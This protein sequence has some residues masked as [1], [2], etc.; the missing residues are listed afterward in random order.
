MS[1]FKV[2]Q[3]FLYCSYLPAVTIKSSSACSYI[4]CQA[5]RHFWVPHPIPEEFRSSFFLLINS[6]PLQ[7]SCRLLIGHF[8]SYHILND[9]QNFRPIN[10]FQ[11]GNVLLKSKQIGAISFPLYQK[12]IDSWEI[13]ILLDWHNLLSG[14]SK[15]MLFYSIPHLVPWL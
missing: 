10:H 8:R 2:I 15:S 1:R 14:D 6:P 9:T 4:F 5:L 13:S 3:L 11:W 12:L 7:A